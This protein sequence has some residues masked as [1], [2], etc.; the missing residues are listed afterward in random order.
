MPCLL[1]SL[2]P[3]LKGG[4]GNRQYGVA[5]PGEILAPSRAIARYVYGVHLSLW[6]ES[7]LA[8][9]EPS[10]PGQI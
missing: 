9:H 7:E 1:D 6:G 10:S 8:R 4:L 3:T 2:V 5:L